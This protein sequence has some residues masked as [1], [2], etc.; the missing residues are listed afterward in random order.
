MAV[1]AA[2]ALVDDLQVQ[3]RDEAAERR[4]LERLGAWAGQFTSTVSLAAPD[5][6]LLEIQGSLTLFG[7]PEALAR[8]VGDG[9]AVL[10]HEADLA[11]APTPL[12]ATWLAR[13]RSGTT[14]IVTRRGAL[15][16]ALA[17]LPLAVVDLEPE[18]LATLAG[19]GLRRLGECLRLPREGLAR[20]LGPAWVRTL[21][22][23]LG[24]VSDPRPA[25]QPPARFEGHLMLPAEVDD[26]E[27]VLFAVH[28]LV[29]ELT[30]V[31]QARAGAVQ[32][33]ELVLVHGGGDRTRIPLELATPVRDSRHLLALLRARLERVALPAPVREVALVAERLLAPEE[34]TRDWVEP[35]R[36]AVQDVHRLVER[37]QARLGAQAVR[38]VC[39]V[40]EHRPER[41]W[42]TCEPGESG[43][44]VAAGHRPLWLLAEPALL[45][46]REGRPWLNREPLVLE[47]DRERIESGWWDGCDVARDYFIARDARGAR[48][49]IYRELRGERRWFLQGVF[50]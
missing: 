15:V 45:A 10:G 38:G 20:R 23:A 22:Q 44:D 17:G 37:L 9:L 33:L 19:S 24:H 14:P 43:A 5:T 39:Q 42:R 30:G 35:A 12:A 18:A 26:V 29:M 16:K 3:S 36:G 27:R 32:A 4:A 25:F 7:G 28:R 40:D 48:L 13:A 8:Q 1:G 6:L 49:W 46:V 21:D 34:G 2:H 47:A 31:L 11:L 41:A 50:G